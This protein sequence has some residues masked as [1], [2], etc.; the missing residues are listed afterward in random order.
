ML[1]CNSKQQIFRKNTKLSNKKK[2]ALTTYAILKA[3]VSGQEVSTY[4]L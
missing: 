3:E 4:R 2:R 1:A